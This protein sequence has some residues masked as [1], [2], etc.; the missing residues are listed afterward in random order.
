MGI[1]TQASIMIGL[2]RSEIEKQELIDNDE[3]EVCAAYYDGTGD[4]EAVA[5]FSYQT[6][7]VHL[8]TSFEWD[9]SEVDKVKARFKALTGQEALIWI[10]P[11][12][13]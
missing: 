5:G 4:D 12:V 3:L 7:D 9:Q 11:N 2:K 1:D 10:S 8:A 13:W 6:S